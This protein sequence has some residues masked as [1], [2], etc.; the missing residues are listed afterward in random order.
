MKDN[1]LILHGTGKTLYSV[2]KVGVISNKVLESR[3]I[4]L[5]DIE[6]NQAKYMLDKKRTISIK[7]TIEP[8]KVSN[9]DGLIEYCNLKGVSMST[10]LNKHA[11]ILTF[12][13]QIK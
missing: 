13:N 12:N 5:T 6:L 4:A 10:T 11:N 8:V 7:Y 9:I 2:A 1:K 3:L